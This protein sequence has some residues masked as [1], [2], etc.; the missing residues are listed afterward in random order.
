MFPESLDINI[1]YHSYTQDLKDNFILE[2]RQGLNMSSSLLLYKELNHNF[3]MSPYL[4]ILVNKRQR[5]AL[6]K[7]RLWSH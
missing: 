1:L 2:W 6:A 5:N 3:E 7:L 4:T